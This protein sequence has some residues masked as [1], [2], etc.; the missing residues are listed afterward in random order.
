M[1]KTII[2]LIIINIVPL[3]QEISLW[4][5]KTVSGRK[6]MT[7]KIPIIGEFKDVNGNISKCYSYISLRKTDSLYFNIV[8]WSDPLKI[9][10]LLDE[11]M[12]DYAIKVQHDENTP[13]IVPAIG[14]GRALHL[15]KTEAEKIHAIFKSGGLIS[16]LITNASV[17]YQFS[18]AIES[19][20]YMRSFSKL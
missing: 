3:T 14:F 19:A 9:N 5:Y 11:K 13:I 8:I 17:S 6:T 1:I 12:D 18:I 16:F 7:T 2:A 4:E 15:R 10:P 20:D